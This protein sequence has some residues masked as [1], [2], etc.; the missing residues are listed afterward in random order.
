M[1]AKYYENPIMLSRVTAKNVGDIFLRHTVYSSLFTMTVA[2]KHNN[3]TEKNRNVVKCFMCC[4][5]CQKFQQTK[6][7]CIILRIVVSFWGLCPTR[8]LRLCPW[9]LWDFHPS[10]P[11][12]AHPWKKSCGRPCLWPRTTQWTVWSRIFRSQAGFHM[13]TER[14]YK[15]W[16]TTMH[17]PITPTSRFAVMS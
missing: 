17:T 7:L 1:C 4:K 6:Y 5:C 2:R 3:S 11:L 14:L 9:T 8:S 13:S 10:D 16:A 12:I 15:N